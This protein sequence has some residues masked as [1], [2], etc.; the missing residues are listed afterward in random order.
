MSVSLLVHSF[1]DGVLDSA[2]SQVTAVAAGRVGLVRQDMVGPLAGPSDSAAGHGDLL[3]DAFELGTV[4]VVPGGQDEGEGPASSVGDEVDLGGEPAAG[5][6]QA[7][8]ELTTSSNRM[9]NFRRM[10]STWFVPGP[11][12]F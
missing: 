6:S 9:A 1:R 3:Q 11:A 7:L 5:T 12:P 10:G 4:T 8:A 2:S